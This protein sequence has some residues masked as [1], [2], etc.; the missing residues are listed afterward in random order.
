MVCLS[1]PSVT[2]T[3]WEGSML[4]MLKVIF[5]ISPKAY[6]SFFIVLYF[7]EAKRFHIS[8]LELGYKIDQH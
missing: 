1:L 4:E 7:S 8:N 2:G 6:I 5:N 3:D